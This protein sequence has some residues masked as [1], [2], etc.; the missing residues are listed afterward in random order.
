MDKERKELLDKIEKKVIPFVKAYL[1]EHDFENYDIKDVFCYRKEI[2]LVNKKTKQPEKLKLY[3]VQTENL[4]PEEGK[5]PRFELECLEDE[6]GNLFTIEELMRKYEEKSFG[7]IGKVV[8]DTEHNEELPEEEQDEELRK[9]TL[10]E[11]KEE[12]EQE[13][14]KDEKDN[15]GETNKEEPKKRKPKHVIEKVNPDKAKMDYWQTVKQ[16]FGLPPQ[17]ATLAFAY[18]VSS[19]DKVD[20]ANITIYML[21]KDGNIIDDL[22]VD[23]YFEFDSSTGNNPIQDE[24]V[25]HEEDENRGTAQIE[26]NRTMIRLKAKKSN[27]KNTYISL[28]Q[29]DDFGDHNDI[30]AGR[31]ILAGTQNVEKQLET[32]RIIDIDSERELLMKSNAGLDNMNDIFGEGRRHQ[33]HE[34]EEYIHTEN[35]DGESQTIEICSSDIIPGTDITWEELSDRTGEGI[36]K[37]Q[38]RFE[39]ELEKGKNPANIVEE[40]EYDYDMAGH[41]HKHD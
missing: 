17:V 41:E 12:K 20:Y 40:I 19:E 23:D 32:D 14:S 37:L 18:P 22:N 34:N 15:E 13:E 1:E 31:K 26:E 6:N 3:A 30:N 7:N 28:E 35:A 8:Q 38:E 27:D 9:D 4:I 10:E 16:A 36:K 33:E 11:L 29:Q 21:D 24:V 2:E 5:D 39:R 25:R